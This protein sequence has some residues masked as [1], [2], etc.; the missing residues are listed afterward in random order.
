MS[1]YWALVPN[2]GG[3]GHLPT[4]PLS[5]GMRHIG[6]SRGGQIIVTVWND[7]DHHEC[8]DRA[9]AVL[10][11]L[12]AIDAARNDASEQ[13]ALNAES[14]GAEGQRIADFIREHAR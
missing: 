1:K 10:A 5:G 7:H 14:F 8:E 12:R 4:A 13:A 2:D 11:L 9:A 6:I 3:K